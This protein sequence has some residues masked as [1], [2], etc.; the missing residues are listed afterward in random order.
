VVEHTPSRWDSHIS[1]NNSTERQHQEIEA[2]LATRQIGKGDLDLV[3]KTEVLEPPD[4][5]Y[6]V[7]N[8]ELN[9]ILKHVIPELVRSQGGTSHL[10]FALLHDPGFEPDK[11]LELEKGKL[12]FTNKARQSYIKHIQNR[13]VLPE[14]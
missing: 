14:G 9:H 11:H 10:M 8:L 12:K 3:L 1:Y 7:R 13:D 2:L 4:S 6:A 5:E